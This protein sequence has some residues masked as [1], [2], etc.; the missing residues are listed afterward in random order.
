MSAEI[1]TKKWLDILDYLKGVSILS[2]IL[3]HSFQLVDLPPLGKKLIQFG[4]TGIHVFIFV[5]GFSLYLSHLSKPLSFWLFIKKRFLK[6]Y[7][8]V[9]LSVSIIA[10]VSLTVPLYS[11]SLY[12]YLGHIFLYKMFDERIMGSYGYHFWFISLIISLY[13]VFLPIVKA[14]DSLP[15]R[16][17]IVLSFVISLTWSLL[18]ISIGKQEIRIWNSF[19]LQYLWEFC[20]GI[21]LADLYKKKNMKFW[22]QKLITTLITAVVSL[23]LYAVLPLKFGS[24]GKVL[25]DIPALVGYM[26]LSIFVYNANLPFVNQFFTYTGKISFALYLFHMLF[27]QTATYFTAQFQIEFNLLIVII[28]FSANYLISIYVHA[29]LLKLYKALN[30]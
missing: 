2:I 13:L 29:L 18:I 16:I 25:N 1:G 8:P 20:L 9:I 17:F 26:S 3:L 12:A 28:A 11:S 27:L 22:S 4:G 10:L 21:C 15:T 19:F 6:I 23:I 24:V 5:S 30:V 14:K 7:I